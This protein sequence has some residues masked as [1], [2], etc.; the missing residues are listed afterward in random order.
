MKWNEIEKRNT[1][2]ETTEIEMRKRLESDDCWRNVEKERRRKQW[3]RTWIWMRA[4]NFHKQI[5]QP[6]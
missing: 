6:V 5:L 3:N 1:I 2:G 4:N